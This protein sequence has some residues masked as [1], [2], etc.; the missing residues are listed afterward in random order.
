MKYNLYVEDVSVEFERNEHDHIV[1]TVT[2]LDF[3]VEQEI[4]RL[5]AAGF[6]MVNLACLRSKKK[7]GYD[8]KHRLV[9]NQIYKIALIP[10]REIKSDA[11]RTIDALL[12][13][14]IEKYG[15]K[16]PLAGI[17]PRIRETV[18]DEQMEKM[19]F[20]Y[21]I[22]PHDTIIE[23][24]GGSP[25]VLSACRY[26]DGRWLCA[27]LV[28]PGYLWDDGGAFAFLVPAS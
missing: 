27:S 5:A 16:K 4:K 20:W 24:S 28:P 21:I 8:K 2:G 25:V 17:V 6:R 7:D 23:D 11:D 12:T 26:G 18:S 19:G 9:A 15:Y 3:T 22:A 14:G 10:A 13:C 1:F